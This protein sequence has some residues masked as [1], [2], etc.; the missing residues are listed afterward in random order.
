MAALANGF[1]H[2]FLDIICLTANVLGEAHLFKLLF[3]EISN[4]KLLIAPCNWIRL[5]RSLNDNS[6]LRLFR[7]LK[8]IRL[9]LLFT[10]E[11]VYFWIEMI[12]KEI[13][14]LE[15]LI[16]QCSRFRLARILNNIWLL[17]LVNFWPFLCLILNPFGIY[18]HLSI[19]H[20]F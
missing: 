13:S 3:Y 4:L 12:M 2:F 20:I 6:W 8:D 14:N 7:S 9:L 11:R 19:R 17:L 1:N 5:V 10:F 18:F 16:A 15:L